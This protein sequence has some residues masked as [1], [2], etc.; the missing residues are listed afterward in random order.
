MATQESSLDVERSTGVTEGV[1]T[2][3]CGP[4]HDAA[5]RA[6]DPVAGMVY[7][8]VRGSGRRI[9]TD[10]IEQLRGV[11]VVWLARSPGGPGAIDRTDMLVCTVKDDAEAGW[12]AEQALRTRGVGLVVVELTAADPRRDRRLTLAAEAGGGIGLV[13]WSERDDR[14]SM[15]LPVEMRSDDTAL[16]VAPTDQPARR[17]VP[18]AVPTRWKAA[19]A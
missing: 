1:M 12:A 11:G 8:V 16:A 19:F 5:L 18:A 17:P 6:D 3:R 7:Q 2:S 9:A 4:G 14:R 13:L 15:S 10:L